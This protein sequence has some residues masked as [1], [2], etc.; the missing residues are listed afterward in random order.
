VPPNPQGLFEDAGRLQAEGGLQQ[1]E[2][3]ALQEQTARIYA[4]NPNAFRS[5]LRPELQRAAALRNAGDAEG[6]N[7]IV[8]AIINTA[9]L[10]KLGEVDTSLVS[11]L[12]RLKA[13]LPPTS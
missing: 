11:G 12:D 6:A 4:A 9:E 1:G 2:L 13:S 10:L 8:R 3:T 5:L 7:Q